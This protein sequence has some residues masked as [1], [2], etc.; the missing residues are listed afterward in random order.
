VGWTRPINDRVVNY[1][2]RYSAKNKQERVRFFEEWLRRFEAITRQN[3]SIDQYLGF[4]DKE[5][6]GIGF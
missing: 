3:T 6:D 5:E 1:G 2:K 4:N